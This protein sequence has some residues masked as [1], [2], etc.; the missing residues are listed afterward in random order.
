MNGFFDNANLVTAFL[1]G[2][3]SFFSP[4]TLPLVPLF[5]GHLVGVSGDALGTTDGAGGRARL[6]RNAGAFVLGFSLVFVVL[7]GLP[8]GLLAE[9]LRDHRGALLRIGGI[10]LVVLGLSY[11]G[12]IRIPA[13]M[14]EW[15][16]YFRPTQRQIPAGGQWPTSLLVGATFALGWTPCIGAI[17]G[18]VMAMALVGQDRFGA[19]LLTVAYSLGLGLPFIAV[20]LGFTR[21]APALRRLHRHLPTLNRI[22]G[23]LIIA[24]GIVMLVG[25]Y[26]AFFTEL[27]RLVPWTP[28]L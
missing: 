18:T 12:V 20:A 1:A 17:L 8:A 25:A 27:I 24:I 14:R 22:A 21:L 6:L 11:L 13:L 15:R 28:P 5:L 2:L 19:V 7:F 3:L 4:C 23:G 26:Q 10:C 16:P 9:A